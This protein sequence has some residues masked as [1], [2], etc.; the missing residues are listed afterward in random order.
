MSKEINPLI[1]LSLLYNVVI[2]LSGTFPVLVHCF[3]TCCVWRISFVQYLFN[4]IHSKLWSELSKINVT[5][6]SWLPSVKSINVSVLPPD[7]PT[8]WHQYATCGSRCL[9]GSSLLRWLLWLWYKD[10]RGGRL[11]LGVVAHLG[12][13]KVTTQYKHQGCLCFP[14]NG[15]GLLVA[16]WNVFFFFSHHA[17]LTTDKWIILLNAFLWE[18]LRFLNRPQLKWTSA[19]LN[20]HG[21]K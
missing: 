8:G 5:W 19:V 1:F 13:S 11:V 16:P 4:F 3:F 15:A 12:H 20:F 6:I 21:G 17:R 14:W 2:Y 10:L 9:N 7:V 18:W